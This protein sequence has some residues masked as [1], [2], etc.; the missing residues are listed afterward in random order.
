MI[1][2]MKKC[3]GLSNPVGMV[4]GGVWWSKDILVFW[5]GPSFRLELEALQVEQ[6]EE[7]N[8]FSKISSQIYNI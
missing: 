1:C 5:C 3:P 4:V 7:Y 8:S 6:Y 2:R